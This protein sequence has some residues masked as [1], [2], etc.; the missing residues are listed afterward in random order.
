MGV[1]KK[2]LV[3][4]LAFEA[5]GLMIGLPAAAQ[6]VE[7]VMFSVPPRAAHIITPVAPGLT[8]I[9]VASNAPFSLISQGA[10]GEMQLSL[11]V[12]GTINGTTFGGQ[13]Q[14]PGSI[15]ECVTPTSPAPTSLYMATRKTAANRGEVISQAVIIRIKYDPTLNPTFTVKTLNQ[16]EAKSAIQAPN[17]TGVS[18]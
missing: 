7:R 9:V 18:S 12:N 16:P 2:I 10:I 4:W 14:H 8:E 1:K 13:A 5:V 15:S 17:C 3:G 6:I 11:R